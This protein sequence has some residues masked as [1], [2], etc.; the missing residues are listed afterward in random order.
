M[1][2]MQT[3]KVQRGVA[4]LVTAIILLLFGP[5]AQAKIAD[6]VA[7]TY[8]V[9]KVTQLGR[10]DRVTFEVHL[11]NGG[12]SDLT[13]SKAVLSALPWN[14]Q[15]RAVSSPLLLPAHSFADISYELTIP[16]QTYERWQKGARLFV[17]LEITDTRGQR[18][19]EQVQLI[20]NSGWDGE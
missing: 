3:L 20:R 6:H 9:K 16:S 10:E 13:N 14:P 2:E 12:D 5:P 8:R 17:S 18:S 15:S 19:T 7:G 11:I 4:L 1:S